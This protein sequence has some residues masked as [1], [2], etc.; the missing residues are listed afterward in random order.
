MN[1]VTNRNII[2]TQEDNWFVARDIETDVASQGHDINSA[3]ANLREA[4]ELY[5]EDNDH[6]EAEYAPAFLTT[7]EFTV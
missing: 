6:E 3:L 7:M 1:R 4:L 2:V 5:Y